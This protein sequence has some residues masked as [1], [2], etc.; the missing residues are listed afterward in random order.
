MKSEDTLKRRC[1]GHDRSPSSDRLMTIDED[2]LQRRCEARD[3]SPSSDRL[4]TTGEDTLEK[5]CGPRYEP[6]RRC[7]GHDMNP[8]QNALKPM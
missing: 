1:E 2:T 8:V 6:Q 7:V 3:R 4:M 5:V